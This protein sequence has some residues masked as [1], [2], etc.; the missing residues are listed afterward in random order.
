MPPIRS[1]KSEA[2][3]DQRPEFLYGSIILSVLQIEGT[4]T[5]QF[6]S[7]PSVAR[8]IYF[9]ALGSIVLATLIDIVS[10]FAARHDGA[11]ARRYLWCITPRHHISS[12]FV[13][14][15]FSADLLVVCWAVFD[16]AVSAIFVLAAFW[17]VVIGVISLLLSVARKQ[18]Q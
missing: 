14:F 8:I 5:P 7:L 2:E 16:S 15:T 17:L 18:E 11:T 4:S 12:V 3:L 9:A 10:V 13:A 1:P 6:A